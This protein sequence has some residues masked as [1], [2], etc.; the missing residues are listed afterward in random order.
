MFLDPS[1]LDRAAAAIDEHAAMIRVRGSRLVAAAQ[2]A[3]W[4]SPAATVFRDQVADIALGLRRSAA[5]LEV[6]ARTL[7]GHAR[8][9]RAVA[10]AVRA[11]ERLAGTSVHAAEGAAHGTIRAASD[12]LQALGRVL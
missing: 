10:E 9:V 4:R 1:E 11:A 8:T 6:A 12:A 3:R 7:R 2:A 5:G